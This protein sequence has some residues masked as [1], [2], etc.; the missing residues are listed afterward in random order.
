LSSL[1]GLPPNVIE[2]LAAFGLIDS[3]E[4]RYRFRDLAAARQL[5]ELFAAGVGLSVVTKSLQDIRKWLPDVGL[6]NLKLFPAANDRLLVEQTKGRT[7]QK[8]QFVLPVGDQHESPDVLFDEA[9]AAEEAGNAVVAERLYRRVMKLDP[10]DP[11]AAFNLGNLLRAAARRAEAESAYRAAVKA[12]PRFAEAWYN[13]ADLLD[14]NGRAPEAIVC[15]ERAL[16]AEPSHSDSIFNLAL[17]LQ[18]AERISEALTYW[19]RY[20]ALDGTSEWAT[21]ARRSL[22]YCEMRLAALP[23]Q[24][25]RRGGA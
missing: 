7:D 6:S 2:Q 9:Q 17:L 5:G 22:K 25:S 13:L 8:G 4:G 1:S 18:R 24:G 21:R 20:L 11:A 15:L 16:A 10:G 12:D 14:D 23:E 3:R 19:R